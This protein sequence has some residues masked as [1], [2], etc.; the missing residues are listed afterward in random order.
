MRYIREYKNIDWDD[1]DIQEYEPFDKEEFILYELY[2]HLGKDI[3]KF[4]GNIKESIDFDEN[5]WDYEEYEEEEPSKFRVGDMVRL[6]YRTPASFPVYDKYGGVFKYNTIDDHLRNIRATGSELLKIIEINNGLTLVKMRGYGYIYNIDDIEL[7]E[8]LDES[9]DF[10]EDDFEWIQDEFEIGDITPKSEDWEVTNE[11]IDF[12]EDDW[13]WMEDDTP[14]YSDYLTQKEKLNLKVGDRVQV[15]GGKIRT[16]SNGTVV[17]NDNSTGIEFDDFIGG[18]NCRGVC[19]DGYG[20][21]IST[22]IYKVRK[23]L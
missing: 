5:D 12:N 20:W 9:F 3:K 18:H 14:I 10:D 22:S 16:I 7:F 6:K 8:K 17:I 2:E 23:I 19:K 1:W 15:H 13:D 4:T 11:S 21:F